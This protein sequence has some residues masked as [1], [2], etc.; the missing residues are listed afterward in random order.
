MDYI[1]YVPYLTDIFTKTEQSILKRYIDI[2]HQ[3]NIINENIQQRSNYITDLDIKDNASLINDPILNQGL[4][5]LNQRFSYGLLKDEL[6]INHLINIIKRFEPSQYNYEINDNNIEILSDHIQ[7]NITLLKFIISD[8][9]IYQQNYFTFNP[10][11]G[12][13]QFLG[14]FNETLESMYKNSFLNTELKKENIIIHDKKEELYINDCE[15]ININD[16]NDEI[17]KETMVQSLIGMNEYKN[18]TIWLY[19]PD[20]NVQIT[21]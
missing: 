14:M 15:I 1:L 4:N 12:K 11:D 18:N 7:Y 6:K 20:I 2:L 8:I 21:H 5:I 19:M 16:N 13:T 9:L 10:E 17:T 3:K